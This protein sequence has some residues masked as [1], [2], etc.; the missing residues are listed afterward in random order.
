MREAPAGS[1]GGKVGDVANNVQA[2]KALPEP[3]HSLITG[4]FSHSLHDV[5]LSAVPLV[6]VALVVSFFLKE[7]PLATRDATPAEGAEGAD[8]PEVVATH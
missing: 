3:I 6:A 8:E 5:F 4:A 7:K 2:I 1:A